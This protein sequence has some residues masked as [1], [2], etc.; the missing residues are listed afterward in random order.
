VPVAAPGRALG[1]L[2]GYAFGFQNGTKEINGAAFVARRVDR[3]DANKILQPIDRLILDTL[4]VGGKRRK[5]DRKYN[6]I[7]WKLRNHSK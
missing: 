3:V 6:E 1:A 7:D 4:G 2:I 5:K